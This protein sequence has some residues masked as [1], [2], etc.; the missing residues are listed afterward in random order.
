MPVA[1]QHLGPSRAAA[2]P[3]ATAE[4]EAG[5]VHRR[6]YARNLML[7]S[8]LEQGRGQRDYSRVHTKVVMQQHASKKGSKK[9]L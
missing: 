9:V 4:E 8:P 1:S 6:C 2:S 7:D 5:E 3:T